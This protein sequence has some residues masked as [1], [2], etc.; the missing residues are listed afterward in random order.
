MVL[1]KVRIDICLQIKI[2]LVNVKYICIVDSVNC[3][4]RCK[5]IRTF[6][7]NECYLKLL[8]YLISLIYKSTSQKYNIKT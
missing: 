1:N 6:R 3:N 5:I 4:V 8:L 2:K 7:D